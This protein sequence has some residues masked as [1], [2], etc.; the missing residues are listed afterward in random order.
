[1][2]KITVASI[3]GMAAALALFIGCEQS[4]SPNVTVRNVSVDF[5][6][7]YDNGGSPLTTEQT[8]AKVTELNLRQTGDRLEAV[9]NNGIIFKGTLGEVS[10]DSSGQASSI[11]DLN[12]R[13][14]ANG[15][16]TISGTII[17]QQNQGVMHGTWIEPTLFGSFLAKGTISTIT[18]NNGGGGGSTNGTSDVGISP[19][20]ASLTSSSSTRSFTASGGSGSYTWR[21]SNSGIGSVNP[22]TGNTVTYTRSSTGTNTLIVTDANDSGNSA[23]ATISQL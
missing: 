10:L 23:S 11:F 8:G 1:M 15:D 17:G 18:T 22:T 14:T 12:G 13:T 9:D 16:V 20:S 2:T 7:F 19:T 3:A 21:V 4:N 6:G 5:S